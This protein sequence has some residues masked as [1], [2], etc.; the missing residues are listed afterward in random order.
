MTGRDDAFEKFINSKSD[1]ELKFAMASIKLFGD[2][3]IQLHFLIGRLLEGRTGR[4]YK[5]DLPS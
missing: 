4:S 2:H 3:A 1:D 5:V